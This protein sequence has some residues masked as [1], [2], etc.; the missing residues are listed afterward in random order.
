MNTNVSVQS[1]AVTCLGPR[2]S[3]PAALVRCHAMALVYCTDHGRTCS[4]C[5]QSLAACICKVASPIPAGDGI[6]RVSREKQGR[7]GKT[8]TMVRG[9]TLHVIA[10]TASGKQL[11]ASCSAGGTAKDGVTLPSL[12]GSSA[13]RG[14]LPESSPSPSPQQSTWAATDWSRSQQLR[15]SSMAANCIGMHKANNLRA[16]QINISATPRPRPLGRCIAD[17]LNARNRHKLTA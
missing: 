7:E 16:L 4:G 14:R 12:C 17:R 13:V 1:G 8:V 11:H 3:C 6:T 15:V 2:K 9:P 10:M 5:R